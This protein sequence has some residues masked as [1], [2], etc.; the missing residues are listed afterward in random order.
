MNEYIE[1]VGPRG[2]L[3]RFR[4]PA[5]FYP[6]NRYQ[7]LLLASAGYF[8]A[9]V[10]AAEAGRSISSLRAAEWCCG[11]GAAAIALKAAGLGE[12]VALDAHPEAV[13]I[14]RANAS[15]NQLTLDRIGL[16]DLLAPPA[17]DRLWDLVLCNPP[18]GRTYQATA[19]MT[20]AMRFAIDGGPTG[21][22]FYDPLLEAIRSRLSPGG[23]LVFVLP[24]TLGY[25]T[26]V[27]RLDQWFPGKWRT[28]HT[29]PVAQPF[30]RSDSPLARL[31]M[32]DAESGDG[33]AWQEEDGWIWRLTWVIV[34]GE[35]VS[36]RPSV[37]R[38]SLFLPRNFE[39]LSSK[40][41]ETVARAIS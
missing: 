19:A 3:L 16:F 17:P 31:V 24:S 37:Q 27:A 8:E 10:L 7:S 32:S 30:V 5:G 26:V 13:E 34:V 12:V 2:R 15:L 14:C 35:Q 1:Y 41:Q 33:F 40:F 36:T 18:C 29:T 23:R 28:D 20:E 4:N 11:G 25:R 39:P 6:V 22:R 21:T 38:E 9:M